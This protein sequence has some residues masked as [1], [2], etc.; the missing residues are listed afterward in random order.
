M[1]SILHLCVIV[2]FVFEVNYFGIC[3]ITLSINVFVCD[4]VHDDESVFY[5]SKIK[6]TAIRIWKCCLKYE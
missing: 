1:F 5:L 2:M 6:F 4:L 3:Q